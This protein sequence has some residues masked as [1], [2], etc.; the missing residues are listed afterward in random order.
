MFNEIE[1][2]AQDNQPL[3]QVLDVPQPIPQPIILQPVPQ[4]PIP[5]PQLMP[6]D[7]QFDE[8]AD[9]PIVYVYEGNDGDE[10]VSDFEPPSDD[11]NA[12]QEGNEPV[13]VPIENEPIENAPVGHAGRNRRGRGSSRDAIIRAKN[14]F[15]AQMRIYNIDYEEDHPEIP[16]PAEIDVP[17]LMTQVASEIR[18]LQITQCLVSH[19]ILGECQTRFARRLHVRQTWAEQGPI[20]HQ[21]MIRL[22]EWINLS[23]NNKYRTLIEYWHDKNIDDFPL[24]RRSSRRPSFTDE[25]IEHMKNMF[26]TAVRFGYP[27]RE[28]QVNMAAFLGIQLDRVRFW[29]KNRRS[30]LRREARE[31]PLNVRP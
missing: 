30:R 18:R 27:T 31:V 14:R 15:L 7:Q 29:V 21:R 26:E 10:N 28:D 12:V 9:E 20:D 23:D 5:S 4:A 1:N 2:W 8:R 6:N 25:Q 24:E 13:A 11:E 16:I 22:Y 17:Q 3:D 19:A